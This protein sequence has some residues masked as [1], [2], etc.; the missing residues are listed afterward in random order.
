MWYATSY[1]RNQNI[2]DFEPRRRA[3]ERKWQYW[4][5]C[6][7]CLPTGLTSNLTGCSWGLLN[8]TESACVFVCKTLE[9]YAITVSLACTGPP[10]LPLSRQ[11][12]MAQANQGGWNRAHKNAI[13]TCGP[14]GEERC[15]I[16]GDDETEVKCNGDLRSRSSDGL[17]ISSW[18]WST[19]LAAINALIRHVIC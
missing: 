15:H 10:P 11:A 13:G 1:C 7:D 5:G 6:S 18:Q 8:N 2:L 16:K 3:K 4:V 14:Y 9:L 17:V 12:N 19:T